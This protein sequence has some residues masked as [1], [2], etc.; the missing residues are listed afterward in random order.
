MHDLDSF[1]HLT[2]LCRVLSLSAGDF[3]IFPVCW[4]YA[5]V[6]NVYRVMN[7]CMD[8]LEPLLGT[9]PRS[10]PQAHTPW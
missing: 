4:L 5:A 7:S 9:P 3:H 8:E 6:S 1:L 10:D 2:M